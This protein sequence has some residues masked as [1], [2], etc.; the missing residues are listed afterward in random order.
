MSQ[1]ESDD[2]VLNCQ[3]QGEQ[4]SLSNASSILY[5]LDL[6]F[7]KRNW[8]LPEPLLPTTILRLL[9]PRFN[10]HVDKKANANKQPKFIV[11]RL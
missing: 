10:P 4:E 9:L 8:N 5:G 7:T 6:T 1:N 11:V 3:N 2:P